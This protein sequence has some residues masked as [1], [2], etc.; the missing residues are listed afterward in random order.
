MVIE[1]IGLQVKCAK[2]KLGWGHCAET[3]KSNVEV[4]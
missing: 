1:I 3:F 2:L 4:K